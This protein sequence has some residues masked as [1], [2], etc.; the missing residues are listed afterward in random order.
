[1]AEAFNRERKVSL[2]MD[3]ETRELGFAYRVGF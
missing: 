2:R 1:V 3:A